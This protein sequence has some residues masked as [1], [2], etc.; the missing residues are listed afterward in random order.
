MTAPD[1]PSHTAPSSTGGGTETSPGPRVAPNFITEIV[2]RDLSSGK[3]P[4]VVTRFPPEPNGYLHLGH[5][6]A[7]FLDFQTA[8]Q[9]GG[10]YHLRLDDTN[11]EGESMEFAQGIQD[12]LAWLGWDWDGNLFYASDNFERYYEYAERL[13]ELGQ[14][15]VDSV[16]GEEMARLR[17]DATTPGTPSPYRDRSV[18]EN[19][20]LFR[21]MRAGEFGDGAH[22]LRAKIDLASPNMKLRDPVLYRILRADHYRAG[23]QWCIYPMYDFQHPLQDALEGVTHSMCSLEFVDN[24]AIYDW[25]MET[26]NFT[27]RPHQYEF[28]RRSLEYTV[29]SKRKLRKL[30]KEGVVSGWDDPRMPTL[31]AQRRLGVTPEAILAFAS[32]IGV[33][34]TNRTVDISVYENAVRNDLN[35]RAP[36]VMAVLDPVRVVIG[37]L[38][39]GETRT[40]SLPYWPHD[41]IRESP[42]GLMA[43]PT[44]ER[45]PPEQAVRDVPLTRELY[46]EREDFSLDPPKGYKRLTRGGTVR[47]RGA[48][49]LRADE[50]ETDEA[51]NVTTIHATLL[52]EDAKAAGVIHWVSAESALPA[53]FRLYD[54]LFRVPNPEGDNPDDIAP[55][56]DPERMGHENEAVPVDTGFLRYL[57]PHSLRVTHGFVEPSVASDPEGTRYQFERQGY[58]WRDPKDS[59]EDALVFGRI[60]TLKD[61]WAKET[62]KAEGR[63]PRAEKPKPRAEAPQATSH[64]PQAAS[65][66]PEQEAEVARLTA[67]G[68]SEGDARTLARDEVLGAFFAGAQAGE[69]AAQVAAWTVNDLAP[70]LRSGESRVSAADLPA[71]AALLAEGQISTRIAR[72]VLA[73]AAESGE[74]PAAIVEREGLRVVTDTGAIEAAIREVMAANPDK[75]EAYRGGKTGLLGF[76]TG[77]VMRATGGKAD[78]KVVAERLGAALNG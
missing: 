27:P 10:R 78:P 65:L 69:H 9:Y 38:P 32:Q 73:R 28:G 3:Y 56:F 17:G 77:Q 39:E 70:G 20:D 30:V 12:D 34:R 55:D 24:R 66:T 36:R 16:S 13:I 46:I 21:R 44:G 49:I 1:S 58:F 6:F 22:V 42:D 52:G 25:L 64:K 57:N 75:V 4:Q 48:G 40:F 35:W 37:N 50:V 15:Y 18:E 8:V 71:L 33:S 45:V 51:G 23:D 11:P 63:E 2:E 74:A 5:T 31:R 26:L 53:E 47:L 43:L 76:F 54:R 61:T 60:I 29:V 7:S 14:A 68:A 67:Q 72:D 41:V 59:R 19:L 62:Q